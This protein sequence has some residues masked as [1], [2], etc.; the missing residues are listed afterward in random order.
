MVLIILMHHHGSS[1]I[2]LEANEE[3]I[4]SF[5][6]TTG[7]TIQIAKDKEDKYIYYCALKNGKVELQYPEKNKESWSKFKYNYYF[8]PN[9]NSLGMN[10]NFLSFNF[11]GHEYVVYDIYYEPESI[12]K[13]GVR[14]TELKTQKVFDVKSVRK[15][16]KGDLSV[17]VNNELVSTSVGQLFE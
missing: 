9:G 4:F 14:Y 5:T 8:R 11:D 3:L 16:V 2:H 15:S 17:L 1:Q 12:N 6:T 7:K 10:H 13:I